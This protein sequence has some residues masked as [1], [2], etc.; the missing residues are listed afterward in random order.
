MIANEIRVIRLPNVVY[1]FGAGINQ[2]VKDWDGLSPPLL[3]NFFNV[4]LSKRK[5]KDDYYSKL[6][7]SVYDYIKKYFRKT[8]DDLAKS[9]FDLEICFT[10]LEQQIKRA[11]SENR[12]EEFQELIKI[13][14]QLISFIAEVLSEFEHFAITSHIM[15]NLGRVIFLRKTCYPYIQL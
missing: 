5:F 2:A 15:R 14:F 1:L 11:E 6:L 4:A 9:P 13:N 12:R 10:L 3:S 7:E 8:K